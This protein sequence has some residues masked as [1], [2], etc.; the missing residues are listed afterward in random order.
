ML[1]DGMSIEI[2]DLIDVGD[3]FMIPRLF[4]R[5]RPDIRWTQTYASQRPMTLKNRLFLPNARGF[6]HI[7]WRSAV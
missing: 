1:H 7:R 4:G 3:N 6:Y 5:S 2:G